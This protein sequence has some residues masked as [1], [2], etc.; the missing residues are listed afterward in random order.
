MCLVA[1]LPFLRGILLGNSFFF[2]DLAR[3]Y[4]PLRLF[5]LEGLLRGELRFWNPWIHEGEP[6]PLPISYPLDVL[7]TLWP[8]ESGLSLSLALHL[9]FAALS[10][11]TLARTLGLNPVAGALGG[12]LYALGGFSLSTLSLYVHLQALAWAPLVVVGLVKASR[13]GPRDVTLSA[14]LTAVALATYGVEV[15][16]QALVFALVLNAS[17]GDV[18]RWWR[19]CQSLLLAACLAA[20]TL[21]FL[22]GLTLSG[23]RAGGFSTK[24]VLGFSMYPLSFAQ[25][26]IAALYSD[27][28]NPLNRFWGG[29]FSPGF[30]YIVS[31]YVGAIALC[32]AATGAV[33]GRLGGRLAL[34]ALFSAWV[35]LGP[36]G[37]LDLMLDL[38]PQLR[39]FRYPA[40]AFFSVHLA[41][42]LLA[43]C[44]ADALATGHQRRVWRSFAALGLCLGGLLAAAPSLPSVFPGATRWFLGGFFPPAMDWVRR[45][46]LAR[47]ILA[48]AAL[49]GIVCLLTVPLAWLVLSGRLGAGRAAWAVVA[50]AACDLLRAGAN[51]NPMVTPAFYRPSPEVSSL[52]SSLRGGRI[53]T[54]DATL[55]RGLAQARRQHQD[56]YEVWGQGVLLESLLPGFNVRH[57]LASAYS[58][59][60]TM[61]VSGGYVLSPQ[62]AGCIQFPAIVE[63]LRRAGVAHVISVQAIDHPS[64]ELR[65]V[66]RPP[67]I[68]PLALFVYDLR[69]SLPLRLVASSVRP[70]PDSATADALASEPGFLESGGSAV[71]AAAAA[72][73]GAI[74]RV[75]ITEE[76]SDHL[77][78][79][80]EADRATVVVV[81]DAWA[82]GWRA[83]VNGRPAPVLRADGRHRAVEIGAGRSE[84]TLDYE[85]P[86]LRLGIGV[87]AVSAVVAL[88]LVRRSRP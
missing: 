32:C 54:C 62:E 72:T 45:L 77:R 26:L 73:T 68:E 5:A 67:R 88:V 47:F 42:A 28:G 58:R 46:E 10:F 33:Y 6:A 3:H 81:R 7:Q 48:D 66:L 12:I 20:P 76:T 25:A 19:T 16:A 39:M 70:V 18:G 35:C 27:P 74:G 21:F 56:H 11:L 60:L 64:L 22:H 63:R 34:W 30:P 1:F 69:A 38:V 71:E 83:R 36:W 29:N 50:L 61:L 84:V 2:R 4:F 59:D 40:K 51:L 80:V 15:T 65:T 85:P 17:R 75:L 49:G 8:A 57:E 31:V 82:A 23:A 43:A 55:G 24:D 52:L 53:F 79:L 78:L 41:V 14:V 86:G 9:P 13:G 44:G 37:R 87:F